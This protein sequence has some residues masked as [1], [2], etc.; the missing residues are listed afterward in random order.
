MKILK[1]R[2]IPQPWCSKIHD[3]KTNFSIHN[4]QFIFTLTSQ[5]LIQNS[6]FYSHEPSPDQTK[7]DGEICYTLSHN[8]KLLSPLHVKIH[9]IW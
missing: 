5:F 9:L 3:T 1:K 2:R 4:S 7:N 8:H 6:T